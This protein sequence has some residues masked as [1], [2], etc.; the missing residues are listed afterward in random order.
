[1]YRT[2]GK[3]I[4]NTIL[5]CLVCKNFYKKILSLTDVRLWTTLNGSV[6]IFFEVFWGRLL[7]LIDLS[8]ITQKRIKIEY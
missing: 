7:N 2:W 5:P 6:S 4:S 8:C 3:M 1:M